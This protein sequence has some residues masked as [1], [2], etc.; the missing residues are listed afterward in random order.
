MSTSVGAMPLS[1][2]SV[3]AGAKQPRVPQGAVRQAPAGP[4]IWSVYWQEFGPINQRNS[5]CHVPAH[6][7]AAA[8][9][10]WADFAGRLPLAAHV[11]DLACGAGI[12]GATLLA[13]RSDLS[14]TGVDWAMVPMS[15][16]AGLT[17]VPGVS[18][19]TLP[20]EDN[21]F[22]AAISLFGI[23][24]GDID[25]T[26]GELQRVLKPGAAFSF[27]VHHRESAILR[28]G[29][30][31]RA[32]LRELLSGKVRNAFL[33]G[34]AEATDQ[35]RRRLKTMYSQSSTIDV[36]I[37][38]LRR[39]IGRTRAERH[40]LWQDM[41]TN[42]EPEIAL[43]AHLERSAKAPHEVGAW[44]GSLLAVT[45]QVDV[46]ALLTSTGEPAAWSVAGTR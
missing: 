28:E 24:Y 25:Q 20:F 42:L 22:D 45:R 2:A 5:R 29:S 37:S 35:H 40:A 17:I 27:L 3:D 38:H 39:S 36:L 44:L 26:A 15:H 33:S 11:L 12:A 46:S 14:V 4:G 21:S 6:A 13:Q 43:L 18:M 8:D 34:N 30:A 9:R 31:R 19:E 41:V 10:H 1:F 16:L 7:Q 32:A 23:E